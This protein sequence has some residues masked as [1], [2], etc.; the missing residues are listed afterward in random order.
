VCDRFVG[1]R[2][3]LTELDD[4][5]RTIGY[6]FGDSAGLPVRDYR[7]LIRV[8]AVT[9]GATGSLVQWQSQFDCD[10]SDEDKA[11]SQVRDF[12]TTGLHALAERFATAAPRPVPA[13]DSIVV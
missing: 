5:N 3:T 10:T 8:H 2:E 13:A 9:E 7:C 4:G 1:H 11:G 12:L 6:V